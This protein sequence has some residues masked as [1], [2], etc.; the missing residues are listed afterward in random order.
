MRNGGYRDSGRG[1]F[2]SA[3]SRCQNRGDGVRFRASQLIDH[4]FPLCAHQ[5]GQLLLAQSARA[6]HRANLRVVVAWNAGPCQW[7]ATIIWADR[8]P[9]VRLLKRPG[10]GGRRAG[11]ASYVRYDSGDAP[12]IA[13][14]AACD[15]PSAI[16]HSRSVRSF[17]TSH[18]AIGAG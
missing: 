14:N 8:P 2:W 3:A 13:A 10:R 4:G 16:R 12:S 1:Q 15:W 17:T 7:R 11:P 9:I 6:T 18:H 5:R